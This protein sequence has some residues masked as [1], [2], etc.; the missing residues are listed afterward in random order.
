MK[1]TFTTYTVQVYLSLWK[2]WSRDFFMFMFVKKRVIQRND[3]G[4]FLID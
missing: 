1:K 3:D 2:I 4:E